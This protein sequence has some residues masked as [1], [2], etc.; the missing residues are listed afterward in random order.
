MEGRGES[1]LGEHP[2]TNPLQYNI[3]PGDGSA[4]RKNND[5]MEVVSRGVGGERGGSVSFDIISFLI[6]VYH[7]YVICMLSIK[8]MRA[9]IYIVRCRM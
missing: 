5:V 9:T 3:G 6:K 8:R 7:S 1:P 4:L 2:L